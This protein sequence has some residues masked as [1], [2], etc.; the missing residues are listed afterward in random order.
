MVSFVITVG[1]KEK[2]KVQIF[3]KKNTLGLQILEDNSLQTCLTF[4]SENNRN[5]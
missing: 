2:D 1:V 3:V 5:Y 4:F